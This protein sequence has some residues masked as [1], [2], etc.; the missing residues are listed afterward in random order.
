M[1]FS[2]QAEAIRENIGYPEYLTN[3]TELA[4][5]FKG[6][7]LFRKSSILNPLSLLHRLRSENF[8]NVSE[9]C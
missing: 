6:V 7:S 8:L 1:L 9:N 3:K 2:Q 4:K 5:E